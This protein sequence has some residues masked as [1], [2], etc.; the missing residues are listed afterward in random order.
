M[1]DVQAL[2]YTGEDP[3]RKGDYG[4]VNL[5][6]DEEDAHWFHLARLPEDKSDV[7]TVRR[8]LREC[9]IRQRISTCTVRLEIRKPPLFPTWMSQP[10][11][12]PENADFRYQTLVRQG[13]EVRAHVVQATPADIEIP[14][15]LSLQAQILD[16]Q[17][18][19]STLQLSLGRLP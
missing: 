6:M 19:L 15:A 5:R 3:G 13:F 7:D 11:V 14:D 18:H 2:A 8:C 17:S 12:S 4:A 9:A 1:G 16:L 10:P